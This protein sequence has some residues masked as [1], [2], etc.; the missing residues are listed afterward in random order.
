DGNLDAFHEFYERHKDSLYT[1]LRNRGRE[2]VDDLFQETFVRFIDALT[3]R[4]INKPKSYLFQI[5]MNLLRNRSRQVKIILLNPEYDVPDQETEEEDEFPVK[6]EE[7]K[8]SLLKLAKEKPEFYDVLH[9]H[10][11]EKMT[12]DRISDLK[13]QNRNT[14]SSRYRYAIHYLR[15]LLQPSLK[16]VNEV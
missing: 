10:I 7:L 1:F 16:L 14:I 2:R 12:F 3:K 11:F 15:K 4:E 8:L 9:L 13:Q 5:A 6:E